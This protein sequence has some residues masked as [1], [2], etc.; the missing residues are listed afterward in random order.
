MNK[1]KLIVSIIAGIIAI[2]VS[3][4]A[5]KAAS[6]AVMIAIV[7]WLIGVA[8]TLFTYFNWFDA[9]KKRLIG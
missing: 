3:V 1:T 2:I 4:I 7:S 6:T 8:V 5:I 9:I